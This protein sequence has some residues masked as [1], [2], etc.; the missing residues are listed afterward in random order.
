MDIVAFL[1]NC[2]RFQ[3]IVK[4]LGE[5]RAVDQGTE[6]F[7]ITILII[8]EFKKR[9]GKKQ[10]LFED[11]FSGILKEQCHDLNIQNEGNRTEIRIEFCQ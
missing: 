1:T 7:W 11:L 6:T 4:G 9:I 3:S 10:N 8:N 2:I 5:F